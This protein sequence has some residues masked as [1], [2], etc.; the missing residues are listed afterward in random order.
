MQWVLL[1]WHQKCYF[2]SIT[3]KAS[4]MTRM[5]LCDS[6]GKSKWHPVSTNLSIQSS[7]MINIKNSYSKKEAQVTVQY[8]AHPCS[9][10][11]QTTVRVHKN[12]ATRMSS[13]VCKKQANDKKSKHSC[14]SHDENSKEMSNLRVAVFERSIHWT[15]FWLSGFCQS[16]SNA[17]ACHPRPRIRSQRGERNNRIQKA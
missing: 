14:L 9:H 5:T 2:G 12:V 8:H 13:R 6:L 10:L 15:Y 16:S 3:K 17:C 1:E 11:V 7:M 4:R